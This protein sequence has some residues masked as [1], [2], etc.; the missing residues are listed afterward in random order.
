[1]R[2][3]QLLQK[4]PLLHISRR[5][6]IE[7]VQPNLAPGNDLGALC[8]S[9]HLLEIGLTG[10]FSFVRMNSDRRINELVLFGELDGTIKRAWARST[11]DR[12]NGFNSRLL[13]TLEH[14]RAVGIELLHLEMRVGIDKH[15]N[16]LQVSGF[17]DRC[18]GTG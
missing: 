3:L 5:M 17:T 10:K 14:G 11:A 4:Y 15:R 8:Q 9:R 18:V 16:R 7:I 1:M 13:G 6:I 2:Q 12:E